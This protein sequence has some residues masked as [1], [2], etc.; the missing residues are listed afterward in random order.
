MQSPLLRNIILPADFLKRG[1]VSMRGMRISQLAISCAKNNNNC[2][3]HIIYI[4]SLP[5][6]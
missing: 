5:L 4:Y 2:F 1:A 3:M 6:V